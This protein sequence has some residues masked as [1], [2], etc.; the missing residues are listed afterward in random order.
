MSSDVFF[1]DMRT[2][3]GLSLL[4]KVDNLFDRA[5]FNDIISPKDLVAVK[6]HFGEK[7]NTAF[8]RPQFARR[9]IDKISTKG[10]KPFLTDANTLYAGSRANAVDHFKTAVENGYTYS[11]VNAPVIIA[12]GLSGK[13]Y[14]SVDI[15]LKHFS[16]VKIASAA[17]HAD[18]M[19]VITHFKGHEA[20][21]FG[22]TIKNVGM[23]L[24]SRSGKQQMHS[25][26]LPSISEEK[27]VGCAKCT[28]W[29]PVGSISLDQKK[30]VIDAEMCIGCGECTVTCPE[31]AIA[32]NWKTDHDVFQEKMVEYTA[33]VLKNK[34]GKI[35]YMS[36]V[37]NVTPDCDCCSWSDAPIVSD[38]GIL[39][40]KDPV[41]L[42]QACIDLVNRQRPLDNSR[43]DRTGN[44]A[45][46]FRAV[47]P[48]ID[49]NAQ[50]RYAEEIGLGSRE[51]N[52]I[53]I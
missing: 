52:L 46:K 11:V 15:G 47:H 8:V 44:V 22:G 5:G 26:L 20:S 10:A 16:K 32:I 40:S 50:L 33:G 48:L 23:G 9:V 45:D 14:I 34:R 43:L 30:A 53:K 29:C 28:Q 49:W 17:Y 42:D 27:C 35:G 6:I 37:M 51:Y 2:K 12:D 25:D 21:G 31:R 7:G 39:A 3:Q 1:A 36:F 13:D 4:D 41:A 19:L 38:V 18:A 24:G